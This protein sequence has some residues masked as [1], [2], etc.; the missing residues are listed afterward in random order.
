MEEEHFVEKVAEATGI[1]VEMLSSFEEWEL[2]EFFETADVD[3][4]RHHGVLRVRRSHHN[5]EAGE[6]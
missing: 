5:A 1:S 4:K 2:V 6:R 3:E